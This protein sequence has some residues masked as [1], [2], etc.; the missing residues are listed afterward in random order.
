MDVFSVLTL[1]G[2]LALFLFGMK[3]M[4]ESLEMLASGRLE[5][6]LSKLTGK[7]S[8]A[9]LLGAAVTAVIQ[10]SSA[11]TVM[12]VGFV[13]SGI[14]SL[15]QAVGVIMGANIGTTLTSWILSLS[16]IESN[17]VWIK[18]LKPS[19]F[20]PIIAM[21]GVVLYMTA[22]D[23]VKKLHLGGICIG[24]G[25][26]MFGM[27]TMSQAMQP[28]AESEG[29]ASI[30]LAVSNPVFGIVVGMLFTAII[31]S[32]SA[33][34]GILQ[35]LC[36]SGTV[37]FASVIPIVLGQNIGTCGTA[38]L[39]S[40]G[41]SKNARRA[42]MIHLSFNMIGTIVFVTVFYTINAVFDLSILQQAASPMAVATV[43]SIFNIGCTAL[44][45]PFSGHLVS[46]AENII[47]DDFA[48]PSN[49]KAKMGA[50]T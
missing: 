40:I 20:A 43:H 42:S 29:F 27:E 10:S 48:S 1:V 19:S 14:M 50:Q 30:L 24:F 37:S 2:G 7:T 23:N 28:L 34:V 25:I 38:I 3:Y 44:L 6:I 46:L 31:Q 35:A 21:V 36:M 33:S 45:Y 5:R 16:G 49:M 9:V 26:L 8:R 47:K 13:N 4:G 32:S 15:R 18:M 17:T 22:K 41:A 11:T 39:S 12:V